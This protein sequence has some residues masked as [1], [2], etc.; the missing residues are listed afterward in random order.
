MSP[1]ASIRHA[2]LALVLLALSGPTALAGGVRIVD[3]SGA[4]DFPNIQSAIDAAI[5]GDVL[6]VAAG[7]YPGFTLDA[8]SLSILGVPAGAQVVTTGGVTVQNL[9]GKRAVLCG[10]SAGQLSV[11][12][13]TGD[14]A[15]QGCTFVGPPVSTGAPA[16]THRVE[17]SHGV[18][19]AGCTLVGGPAA[20][21]VGCPVGFTGGAG[22][23][24]SNSTIAADG[25]TIQGGKGGYTAHDTGR[26]GNG[27]EV[28]TQSW[29]FAS[30]CSF[31]GGDSGNGPTCGGGT[32][33]WCGIGGD[34]LVV[35]SGCEFHALANGYV[36][37][38][39]GTG[40]CPWL[41]PGAGYVCATAAC[42]FLPGAAR[43]FQMPYLSID[44]A[45]WNLSVAG[46]PADQI[47]LNRSLAPVFQ[48]EPA[49]SGVCTSVLPPF[50]TVAPAGVLP[51]SGMLAVSL[52]QRL[53]PEDVLAR[54]HYLQGW[55]IE[56]GGAIV[57]G[58][59]MHVVS[60]N[61]SS[62]PDCNA[63]GI[64]DYAEVILGVTPDVDHNLVPD[65]CP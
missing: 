20:A 46:V 52:R 40:C 3:P 31:V 26:G 57:L 30:D 54:V 36:G 34:G 48:Y 22:L 7:S 1:V 8:K 28:A 43:R 42:D 21:C 2:A 6:L 18:V 32:G 56:A 41:G 35:D 49:L 25:C 23:R 14:L 9:V 17:G 59:P 44:R 29:C 12:N 47:F 45:P 60:L 11:S 50:A 58:S 5:D 10:L 24:L 53:L 33:A 39:D 65:G 19:F 61:W 55:V 4:R 27:M 63:N 16:T 15:F 62:L 64:Q 38:T 51:A 13:C 37:G